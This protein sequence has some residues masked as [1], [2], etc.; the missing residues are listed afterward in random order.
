[1]GNV[2]GHLVSKAKGLVEGINGY[3]ILEAGNKEQRAMLVSKLL[4]DGRFLFA[5]DD[6]VR[7]HSF[8]AIYILVS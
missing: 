4:K 6:E 3:N 5:P 7:Y 8:L 1:M 2:R